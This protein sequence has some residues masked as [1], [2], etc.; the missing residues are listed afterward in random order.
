[1]RA[2]V[3]RALD[4]SVEVEGKLVSQIKQGLIVY[5]AVEQGDDI[6][7]SDYLCEKILNLRVFEDE[8]GYM[9]KS[10]LDV[11]EELM[12]ISQFTLM[13]D[14]RKGRRPSWSRAEKPEL[15]KPLYEAF[16]AACAQQVQV[17]TG[18][19]QADMHVKYTNKGP[20]SLLIDSKKTF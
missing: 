17:R 6:K 15:A 12:I 4:C 20:V 9:N 14:C 11:K 18:I 3:Q 10:L 5:L 16:C 19:F 13:G 2:L 7:D 8:A 1:M